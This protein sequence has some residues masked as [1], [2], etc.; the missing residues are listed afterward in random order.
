MDQD[1]KNAVL[2]KLKVESNTNTRSSSIDF[3]QLGQQLQAQDIGSRLES[4]F[5]QVLSSSKVEQNVDFE[6]SLKTQVMGKDSLTE[7]FGISIVPTISSLVGSF[8]PTNLGAIGGLQMGSSIAGVVGGYAIQKLGKSR[9][10][11]TIGSGVVKGSL[12]TFMAGFTNTFLGG[13]TSGFSGSSGSTI[14]SG[15]VA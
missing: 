8:I 3:N 4:A 9:M 2:D 6:Q 10:I 13:I 1:L 15:V 11:D 12:A 7:A 5:N 14:P